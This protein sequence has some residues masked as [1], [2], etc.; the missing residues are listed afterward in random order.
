MAKRLR[1]ALV[2]MTLLA[3]ASCASFKSGSSP[4]TMTSKGV[5][6]TDQNA[7]TVTADSSVPTVEGIPPDAGAT[8]TYRIGEHDLLKIEVFQ[9]SELSSE[10]RVAEDGTIVMPLIG[11]VEIG[12][13]TPKEAEERIAG[14]L[15]QNYLQDPQVNIFVKE[16][17]SQ[18]VTVTG[19]VKQPGV[20]PLTGHT[21]LL[22]AVA[23]AG[24][25]DELANTKG[26]ILFRGES[27]NARAYVIN[28]GK[29]QE[30]ALHDPTIIGNDRIVV[31]K[32]G[33][34]K[35][36]KNISETLRGFV[37]PM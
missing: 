9:V 28:L 21:T 29:I 34:A 14:I 16:Y 27:G 1:L 2:T 36:I 35:L 10:E 33:S 15:A 18:K 13:S 37:R 25:A 19:S 11:P 26:I 24:G 8:D 30:G 3:I 4:A 6:S 32:S 20:F 22:Q 7:N 12:G 5:N 31:P 17:A 23:L